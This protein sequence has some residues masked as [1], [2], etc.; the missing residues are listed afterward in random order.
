[1]KILLI[2]LILVLGGTR[3]TSVSI[4]DLILLARCASTIISISLYFF[5]LLCCIIGT[6]RVVTLDLFFH[7]LWNF[8]IINIFLFVIYG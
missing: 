8:Q 1:M 6:I 4:H 3:L 5:S 7:V 2:W